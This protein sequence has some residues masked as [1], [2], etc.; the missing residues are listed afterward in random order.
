M[1]TFNCNC[2]FHCI[3]IDTKPLNPDLIPTGKHEYV[4][5]TIYNNRSEK[6]GKLYKKPIE[7]GTVVLIGKEARKFYKYIKGV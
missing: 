7:L 6:T 4:G 2:E 1:K 5:L 3:E